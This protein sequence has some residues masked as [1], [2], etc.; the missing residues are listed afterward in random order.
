MFLVEVLC[1]RAHCLCYSIC[2]CYMFRHCVFKICAQ[3]G[4]RGGG[5]ETH[6]LKTQ[7]S[8]Q[9]SR[10]KMG[11]SARRF[12]RHDALLFSRFTGLCVCFVDVVPTP[13]PTALPTPGFVGT[14]QAPNISSRDCPVCCSWGPIC[15]V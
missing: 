12:Y 3:M 6:I 1:F 5:G 2:L 7:R 4:G 8:L 9:K 14:Q 11:Q 10:K 13:V 15:V